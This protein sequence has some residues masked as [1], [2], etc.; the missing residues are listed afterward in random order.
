MEPSH[1]PRTLVNSVC[2]ILLLIIVSTIL[3]ATKQPFMGLAMESN[4]SGKLVIASI[5][6]QDLDKM[7]LE[8]QVIYIAN[9]KGAGFIPLSAHFSTSKIEKRK[10]FKQKPDEIATKALIYKILAAAP[11]TLTTNTGLKYKFDLMQQRP[12]KTL[13]ISFW[14]RLTFG[15]LAVIMGAL[16]WSWHPQKIEHILLLLSGISLML[17]TTPSAIE[18]IPM[19]ITTEKAY[20]VLEQ[21]T[22]IGT[23]VF[24]VSSALTIVFF[25]SRLPHASTVVFATLTFFILFS[26]I[27]LSNKWNPET[28]ILEQTLYATSSERYLAIIIGYLLILGLCICQWLVTRHRPLEHLQT[29][30]VTLAWLTG[31]TIL[32]LFYLIPIAYLKIEPPL[33]RTWAWGCITLSYFLILIGVGRVKLFENERYITTI[34]N[35]FLIS[36]VFISVDLLLILTLDFDPRVSTPMMLMIVLWFYLPI[37]RWLYKLI[38]RQDSDEYQNHF[39]K[40]ISIL[41]NH[42]LNTLD[43]SLNTWKLALIQVFKPVSF[44]WHAD[45]IETTDIHSSGQTLTIRNTES[46]PGCYLEFAHGGTRLFKKED[47]LLANSLLV[48][49]ENIYKFQSALISGQLMERRRIGRD[50]HDHIGHSLLTLIYTAKDEESR[51]LAQITMKRL[52]EVIKALDQTDIFLDS[53]IDEIT[54]SYITTAKILGNT[55]TIEVIGNF[56]ST[57]INSTKY[58]NILS[59]FRELL[60]NT[61]KHSLASEISITI[62]LIGNRLT[63]THKDNGKG[64]ETNTTTEGF[65]LFNIAERAKEINADWHWQEQGRGFVL[66]AQLTKE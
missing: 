65:G 40:G 24:L 46:T 43:S 47:V 15:A 7:L 26:I 34:W 41:S 59:I 39:A 18:A 64:F 2:L 55:P 38:S 19:F 21:L 4:D 31:P 57:T 54:A 6:N 16:V 42:S 51:S 36:L 20:W 63:I 3:W 29:K 25:P 48:F 9:S 53:L 66:S 1:T 22:L 11:L 8:Q 45:A 28:G 23:L 17:M 13:G 10:A 61:I 5:Q 27:I 50:L 62:S 14:L 12:I 37:R 60:S 58:L 52:R 56:S 49:F 33:S 44:Q 32:M 35:W 30:S